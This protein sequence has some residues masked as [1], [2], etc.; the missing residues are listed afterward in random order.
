MIMTEIQYLQKV[1]CPYREL[2]QNLKVPPKMGNKLEDM[3]IYL[4]YH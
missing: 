1:G 3:S 4:T 2:F